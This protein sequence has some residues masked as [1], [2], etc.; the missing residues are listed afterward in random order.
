MAAN[1]TPQQ[2]E[3]VTF[4]GHLLIVAGPGSGKT[5]TSVAKAKRILNDPARSLVMV[6]FTKEAAE[7]M[8]KRLAT[9]LTKAGARIPNEER[10]SLRLFASGSWGHPVALVS[11]MQI[12]PRRGASF[13]QSMC[14]VRKVSLG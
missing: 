6:T 7:E 4:D 14:S 3:A 8:R 9:A 10:L 5:S 2:H 11:T 1:L 12:N 13:G